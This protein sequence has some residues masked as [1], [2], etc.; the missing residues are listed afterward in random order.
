[1]SL[2]LQIRILP[3]ILKDHVALKTGV[4]TLESPA[5]LSH[6]C[7]TFG[8]VLRKLFSIII[9]FYKYSCKQRWRAQAECKRHPGGIRKTVPSGHM[10]YSNLLAVWI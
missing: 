8:N 2:N 7:I 10:H 4:M 3:R 9:I 6:E 1:M 5:L